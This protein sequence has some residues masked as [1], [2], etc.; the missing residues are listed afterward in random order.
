MFHVPDSPMRSASSTGPANP[1]SD[2]RRTIA[3]C[4]RPVSHGAEPSWYD[5][6]QGSPVI[7]S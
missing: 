4:G 1:H 2:A 3:G 5:A 6:S 7:R